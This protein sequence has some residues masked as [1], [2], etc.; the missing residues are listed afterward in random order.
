M[1]KVLNEGFDYHDLVDQVIPEISIDEYAAKMGTNDEIV[2]LTFTTKGKQQASDLVDWLERGYDFVLD[3]EVSEG[4]VSP[5]KYLVF[6]EMNRRTSVPERIC[7][8]VE[9]MK[10]LTDLDSDKWSVKIEDKEYKADKE[11]LKQH[12]ILSPQKYRELKETD[13]NEMRQRA[14]LETH[15]IYSN[16]DKILKDY[17]AKAGL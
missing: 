11:I 10:T 17:L 5:G 6:V 1:N 16:P 9:D 8:M 12:I 3:A 13:L 15:K 14:G 7:E 4:E 2:T